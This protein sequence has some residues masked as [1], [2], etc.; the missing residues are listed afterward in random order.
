MI[1]MDL[2]LQTAAILFSTVTPLA[3]N[4]FSIFFIPTQILSLFIT[5]IPI[6]VFIRP[7]IS[8]TLFITLGAITIFIH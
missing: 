4:P 1:N 8:I 7:E 3:F 5:R 6:A 2:N